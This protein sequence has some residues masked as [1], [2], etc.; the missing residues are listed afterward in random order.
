MSINSNFTVDVMFFMMSSSSYMLNVENKMSS[1]LKRGLMMEDC[2][3]AAAD[4][5]LVAM[6]FIV[7]V[8]WI[9]DEL[10]MLGVEEALNTWKYSHGKNARQ[11]KENDE[12]P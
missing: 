9:H 11:K 10:K 3:E 4:S 6:L 1:S 12:P 8:W 2:T 7:S 5:T